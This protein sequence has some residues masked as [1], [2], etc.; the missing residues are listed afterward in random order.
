MA[1]S[2]SLHPDEVYAAVKWLGCEGEATGLTKR[3]AGRLR[4]RAEFLLPFKVLVNEYLPR[5]RF[6]NPNVKR[7]PPCFN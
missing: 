6:Y 2:D 4:Q 7:A 3:A 5:L 1:V